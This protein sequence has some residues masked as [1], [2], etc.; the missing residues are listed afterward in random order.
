MLLA[1]ASVC[2]KWQRGHRTLFTS[3]TLTNDA[4]GLR[5][6]IHHRM[7]II[8]P[9]AKDDD[10]ITPYVQSP[11]RL[12]QFLEEIVDEK[13]T[14]YPVDTYVNKAQNNDEGCIKPLK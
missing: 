10:W 9:K 13:L 8:L 3:T 4:N 5:K 2:E 14:A 12:K 11:I 6:D 7:P 1:F